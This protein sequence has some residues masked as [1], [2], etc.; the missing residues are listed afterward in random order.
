[1]KLLF[2]IILNLFVLGA[3]GE[4]HLSSDIIFSSKDAS[5][6]LE[7]YHS[8]KLYPVKKIE[9]ENAVY[10]FSELFKFETHIPSVGEQRYG[11]FAVV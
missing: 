2:A 9:I 6:S 10:H 7:L 8:L 5:H 11:V 4:V 3:K 1:M